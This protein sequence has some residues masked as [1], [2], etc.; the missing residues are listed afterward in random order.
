MAEVVE[1]VAKLEGQFK[2]ISQ[3]FT[4]VDTRL[5]RVDETLTEVKQS[6]VRLEGRLESGLSEVRTEIRDLRGEMNT[7]FRWLMSGI[8]AAVLASLVAMFGR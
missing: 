2:T 6:V 3:R 1:R 8:G 7:Q 4:S 5:D